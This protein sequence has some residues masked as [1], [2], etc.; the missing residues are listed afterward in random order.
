M[1]LPILV[2]QDKWPEFD[3]GWKALMTE[4]GP[5]DELLVALRLAGDK[6]RIPRC[7]PM[8]REH[9]ELLEAG[10]NPGDAARVLGATLVAGGNPGELAE[11]LIRLAKEAWSG[12]PWFQPYA[13]LAGLAEGIPDMRAPWKI[14][15]KICLFTEGSLVYHP[16]GWGTGE[17]TAVNPAEMTVD[18]R[19]WNGKKDTFPMNAASEIF[20]HL[21]ETDLRGQ[22][23]RD[24]EGLRKRA[25][26]EP[27]EVL[28]SVVTTHHGRATTAAI[29]NALMAI[30][31]EGSA[32]SAWWRK[33]RKLA[34]N[35][36]WFEVAGT[37]QKSVIT[38]LLTAKDPKEALRKQLS[39]AGGVAEVHS[40]VRD[41]FVGNN[42][43]PE[44]IEV[45]LEVLGSV[46]GDPGEPLAERLAAWL[47]LREQRGETPA[48]LLPAL[49]PVLDAPQP[50]DP[51]IAPEL[52][53]LMQALPNVRDQE[54]AIEVLPELLG[55]SWLDSVAPH[56]PHAA[57]GQVRGLVEA[58]VKADRKEELRAH[59]AGLLARPLRAPALLVSLA[60]MFEAEEL[61][62]SFPTPAQR[63]QALLNLATH[64]YRMRR[65]N[66]QLTRVCTRL[67]DLLAKGKS[68]M[69]RRLLANADTAALRSVNVTVQRGTDSEIDHLVTEIALEKD[70]HFFAGQTGPFWVGDTIWTT[71]KG[72]ERRSLELK[73]LR[74]VKIPANEE[75]IGRA[76]SYG[77]LSENAEWE[78]AMEEQRNLTS[79]AMAIEEELRLA[80]LIEEAAIPEDTVA[81]GT[82]VNYR[83]V[84]SG[85]ERRVIL[86]GPWDDEVWNEIQVVSYRAPLA[87]GLLGLK[88]GEQSTLELPSGSLDIQV[89]GIE[90]PEMA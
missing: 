68:P 48:E 37:P 38:I 33:A 2:S 73:E 40:K 82:I 83:E 28:R 67:T 9:A 19:F 87:K 47:L 32:W 55:E 85:S 69:L 43:D 46:S 22:Y 16:G 35:S 51:S 65:G 90:T 54:R 56:L 75:A 77:D 27:L 72:L 39:R 18:V 41:L 52:F 36:E 89:L 70:R 30:G 71:K 50:T 26:K 5:I 76:A 4:S 1:S 25:K 24:P 58:M 59:Y 12:E 44:L 14:Y 7:T 3:E 53:V 57:A 64:L 80:D 61:D 74:E 63:A 81:P 49:Q 21:P 13:D 86:L 84:E 6:K 11:D 42:P 15:S 20:E 10:G 78:A 29:R 23:F 17:I 88:P 79:R 62:G 34:E 8:A 31:I 66:P 60:G 45:A